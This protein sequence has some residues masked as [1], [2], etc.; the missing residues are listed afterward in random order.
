MTPSLLGPRLWDGTYLANIDLHARYYDSSLGMFLSPDPAGADLN[1]YRYSMNDPVNASDRTGLRCTVTLDDGSTFT[2]N[3]CV[4]VDADYPDDSSSQGWSSS[5]WNYFFL[6]SSPNRPRGGIRY[7]V[8][9]PAEVPPPV[10]TPTPEPG[11]TPGPTPTPQVPQGPGS[12]PSTAPGSGNEPCR[13]PGN[14]TANDLGLA[15]PPPIPPISISSPGCPSYHAQFEVH[16]SQFLETLHDTHEVANAWHV[17]EFF[18]LTNN[19]PGV[20]TLKHAGKDL[21]RSLLATG[22]LYLAGSI[23]NLSNALGDWAACTPR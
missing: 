9:R 21:G 12:K 8:E 20:A 4:N 3:E 17:G 13:T 19:T 10:V 18:Y 6:G 23:Q 15:T 14:C 11:P 2:A 1:T 5:F 7:Y 22:A 16:Q